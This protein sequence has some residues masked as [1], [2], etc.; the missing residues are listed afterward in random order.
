L[1]H[2]GH[3]GSF[4]RKVNSNYFGYIPGSIKCKPVAQVISEM[5][6]NPTRR[7]PEGSI[8]FMR[9]IREKSK[10]MFKI[11]IF[12]LLLTFVSNPLLADDDD[13]FIPKRNRSTSST[14]SDI[15]INIL[16][17]NGHIVGNASVQKLN[18]GGKTYFHIISWS[19]DGISSDDQKLIWTKLQSGE[20]WAGKYHLSNVSAGH[21][22]VDRIS[23]LKK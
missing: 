3:I 8:S 23:K 2:K 17:E 9:P 21:C 13:D 4:A 11:M 18:H 16:D 15:Q 22:I 19:T 1:L 20:S 6:R 10:F 7:S 14:N 5:F 12:T